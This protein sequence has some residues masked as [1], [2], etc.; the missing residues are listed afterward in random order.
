[1]SQ[2]IPNNH[3]Y[4]INQTICKDTQ[5]KAEDTSS[6]FF[7][8]DNIEIPKG[9]PTSE[10]SNNEHEEEDPPTDNNEWTKVTRKEKI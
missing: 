8:E 6:G 4:S 3:N 2:T 7:P 10:D 1:M 9:I 5:D